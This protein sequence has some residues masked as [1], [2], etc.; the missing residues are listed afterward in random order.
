M[1]FTKAAILYTLAAAA[2]VNAH[3]QRQR[4]A[5]AQR[6]EGG[7]A[8]LDDYQFP[9]SADFTGKYELCFQTII[10]TTRNGTNTTFNLCRDDDFTPPQ[11]RSR[12]RNL[13]EL[14]RAP[15]EPAG[16]FFTEPLHNITIIPTNDFNAYQAKIEWDI[17]VKYRTWKFQGFANGK[18]LDM[19]S[20][21]VDNGDTVQHTPDGMTCNLHNSD[22]LSCTQMFQ[23]YC[24]PQAQEE[25]DQH[26]NRFLII[27]DPNESCIGGEGEWLSTFNLFCVG[28][29]Y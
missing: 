15:Q 26:A 20:F 5:K 16:G 27:Q 10:L 18:N 21:G 24:A 23:E 1:K 22:V 28:K 2:N 7:T 29:R 6:P 14:G 25:E 3:R 4:S 9:T 11:T 13:A 8:G 19:Q 17:F 12:N